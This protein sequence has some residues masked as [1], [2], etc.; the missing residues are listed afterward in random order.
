MELADFKASLKSGKFS[1]IYVFAGEEDYLIRYYLSELRKAI[2]PD[3]AL[4]V[5]NNP[6]FEGEKPDFAALTEA[7]KSP[8]M[9]S[10][11]KLVEWRRADFTSLKERELDE[12]SALSE[13][14]EEHPY[15]VV[16]FSA[17][18][19]GIDFGSS[20]KPSPFI[21]RFGNRLNIL[22]FDKSTDSQLY[23]WLGKH[24]HAEGVDYSVDTLKALVFH[25]GHSMDVLKN[26][27]Q[28]LAALAHSRNRSFVTEEDVSEVC[29]STP[30]C[31]TYAL[32]NAV[33]ERNRQMAFSALEEMKIKRVDPNVIMGM[34]AKTYNELLIVSCYI[35]EGYGAADIEKLTKMNPYKLKL[36]ISAVKRYGRPRLSEIC[37]SLAKTDAASKMGGVTGYTA[38][39]MF[40]SLSL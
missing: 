26:E 37:E 31:D 27:V 17:G 40:M 9:M 13:I 16:A 7:C 39:E 24:F 12:L 28:K 23:A 11:Y 3:S 33:T 21:K 14:V 30:E 10:D 8:P 35:E 6:V 18:G 19:E 15:S 5:F 1:G 38:I 20:K 32:S 36:Y 4:A 25:S 34:L 29:S 2:S 22:R